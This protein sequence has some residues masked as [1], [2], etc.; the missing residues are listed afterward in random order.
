MLAISTE[1]PRV[2][3][4]DFLWSRGDQTATHDE[5]DW[6][7]GAVDRLVNAIRAGTVSSGQPIESAEVDLAFLE[8]AIATSLVETGIQMARVLYV[9]DSTWG[10]EERAASEDEWI[11][12]EAVVRMSPVRQYTIRARVRS[13]ARAEALFA[14]SE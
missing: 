10:V 5:D 3:W 11:H 6:A 8:G 4:Y 9:A 13:I 2:R 12:R 1:A 14:T 7:D